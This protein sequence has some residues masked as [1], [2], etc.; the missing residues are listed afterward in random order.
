MPTVLELVARGDIGGRTVQIVTS[1][2]VECA[3]Y[4]PAPL[5][6]GFVRVQTVRTAI[7]PGTEMTL[8]GRNASNVYLHKRWNEELRLFERAEPSL[9][10]PVAFGYRATGRVIDGGGTDVTVGTRVYGNWRHTALTAMP[11]ATAKAQ[12]LPDELSW[13][14]GVDIGQMGPICVN[15]VAFA[16]G[17]HRDHPAVV[18][19]AGPVGLITAQVAARDGAASVTVVDRVPERLQIAAGLGFETVQAADGVDV[20]AALKRRLGPDAISVAWECSGSTFGLHE[21]IRVVRRRGLVVA[22]GFYQGEATGLLLGDEF[23]HNGVRISCGQIGNI[24][25]STD[26][27]GLRAR[28][29]ELVMEHGLRLGD[30]PRVIFPVEQVADAFQALTR[31]GE[32]LQAVLDYGADAGG[33]D[34]RS[35]H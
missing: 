4:D 30:L 1:G 35:A 7:S 14:D 11:A 6:D 10:Y 34:D 19:G 28:T 15:A 27:A 16:E 20:A 2:E 25:P 26:L 13:D 12:L 8:Y 31:P 18:F 9:S 3:T 21:A 24:H 17:E 32:V 29:V 33:A 23:H 5:R 22:V